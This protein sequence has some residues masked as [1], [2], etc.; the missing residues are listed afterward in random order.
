MLI[1]NCG[2]NFFLKPVTKPE[3]MPRLVLQ[4]LLNWS[5]SDKPGWLTLISWAVTLCWMWKLF[6]KF[7]GVSLISAQLMLQTT[8]L[9]K[10]TGA[11]PVPGARLTKGE[12]DVCE[13]EVDLRL[14]HA[15]N[16]NGVKGWGGFAL[17]ESPAAQGKTNLLCVRSGL[18]IYRGTWSGPR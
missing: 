13:T 17:V 1:E 5:N 8:S 10:L 15:R 14:F 11:R 12:K 16:G 9:A 6:I 18:F 2:K 3:I 4:K 7:L